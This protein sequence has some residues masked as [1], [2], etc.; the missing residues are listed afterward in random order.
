MSCD[1]ISTFVCSSCFSPLAT[2]QFTWQLRLSDKG[3]SIFKSWASFEQRNWLCCHVAFHE[4]G[5]RNCIC[6][7]V[8]SNQK[9]PL[10]LEQLP[11]P[12]AHT[13]TLAGG[14]QL[15]PDWEMLKGNKNLF[16]YC[17]VSQKPSS[18]ESPKKP[19][20]PQSLNLGEGSDMFRD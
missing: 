14:V 5:I 16:H 3:A 19:I 1:N 20:F 4:A 10:R 6:Q 8:T 7:L 9:I 18:T 2:W 12:L 15:M 13:E 17:Q 11:S